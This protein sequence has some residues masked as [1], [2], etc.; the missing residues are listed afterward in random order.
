[1]LL[2]QGES[3]LGG[4]REM[5]LSRGGSGVCKEQLPLGEL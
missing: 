3:I 2:A 4:F 1:M 5:V